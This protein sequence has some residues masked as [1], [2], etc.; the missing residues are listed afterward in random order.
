MEEQIKE[1][2]SNAILRALEEKEQQMDAMLE[3]L[4]QLDED[5]FERLRENRKKEMIARHEQEQ[6]WRFHNHGEFRYFRVHTLR[7]SMLLSGSR[8]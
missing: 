1:V 2:A 7:L 4:E 3:Q 6:L 8:N 5:D